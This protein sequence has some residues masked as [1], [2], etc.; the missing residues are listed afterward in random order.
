MELDES[1]NW[2]THEA[3]VWINAALG[4]AREIDSQLRDRV[5]LSPTQPV[6][7]MLHGN[8]GRRCECGVGI[9][10]A[11]FQFLRKHLGHCSL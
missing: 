7:I 3:L 9:T 5:F 8:W 6:S 10:K 11:N 2:S 4:V 1:G